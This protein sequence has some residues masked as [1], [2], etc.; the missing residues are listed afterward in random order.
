MKYFWLF[1]YNI[2]FLPSFWISIHI[3]AIFNPKIRKALRRRHFLFKTLESDIKTLDPHKKNIVLQCSSLGEFHEA[4]PV[5]SELDKSDSY[6]FIVSF[7]SPSGYDNFNPEIKQ[8]LTNNSKII[9]TLLPF[10]WY[11]NMSRFIALLNPSAVLLIKYDL[12]YNF[13]YCLNEK[14]VYKALIN[15]KYKVNDIKWKFIIRSFYKGMFNFLNVIITSDAD[16]EKAF[17]RILRI[18]TQIMNYGDTKIEYVSKAVNIERDREI[19]DAGIFKDKIIFVAGSTWEE[20]EDVILPVVNEISSKYGEPE[21]PG[22]LV[23]VIA[24]HEPDE[25]H[26]EEIETKINS[27][28]KNIRAI[29]F[30]HLRDYWN[31]NVIVIDSIGLLFSLYKYAAIAYVGGGFRTGMHNV[32]EPASYRI[33][34]MFGDIKISEDAERLLRTG[35]GIAVKDSSDLS[36]RLEELLNEK[37]KRKELGSRS[38]NVFEN[39]SEPSKKIAELITEI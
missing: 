2:F 12:W 29:R 31:Q 24:P 22:S 25:F 28:F 37:D 39:G 15:A 10:D 9:K 36:K 30:S 16:S 8:E 32:L 23:T 26:L 38:I 35:S 18:D 4:K 27:T 6:N 5:I 21:R 13:L 14:K 1:I 19:I 3:S 33:P 7:F 11:W 17:K 20:D 34:V